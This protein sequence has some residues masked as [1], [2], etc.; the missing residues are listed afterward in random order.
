M[1]E[2]QRLAE[3]RGESGAKQRPQVAALQRFGTGLWRDGADDERPPL[4]R[5][6]LRMD[7]VYFRRRVG[8]ASLQI[9]RVLSSPS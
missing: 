2:G 4:Q 9:E 5:D 3:G 7:G 6:T 1:S 8:Q